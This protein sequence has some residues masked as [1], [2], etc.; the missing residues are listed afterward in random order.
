V[1]KRTLPAL[2]D[3]RTAS[4]ETGL[5]RSTVVRIM[6]RCDLVT[7]PG[8]RRVFVRRDDFERELGLDSPWRK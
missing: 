2:L 6:R 4:E 3:A 5:P 7:P 1:T 8:V